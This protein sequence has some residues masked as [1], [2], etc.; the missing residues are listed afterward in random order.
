M[1]AYKFRGAD[2]IPF[3][4][5]IMLKQRLFCANWTDL[6]DPMEGAFQP[7]NILEA[8]GGRKE[9]IE[10]IIEEKMKLK[11]CS[12]AKDFRSHLLWAHYADGFSGVAIEVELPKAGGVIKNVEYREAQS[13]AESL[14][15]ISTSEA[16]NEILSSKFKDW[17]YE[18]EV[19][20][21]QQGSWY[22]LSKPVRRIICGHR[23]NPALFETL[24]I[25]CKHKGIEI[26]Q[27]TITERGIRSLAVID[28]Q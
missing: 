1:K 6:N 15:E 23:M 22:E 13:W 11:V 14:V 17:K 7:Q 18:K 27:T 4:L 28:Q 9:Q 12:L 8:N 20:V 5:D 24:Q 16:A 25:L 19:R 3:A 21:L 2:Q 10:Q 26:L